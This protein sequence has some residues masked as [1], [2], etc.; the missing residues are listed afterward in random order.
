MAAKHASRGV[1][2]N[3]AVAGMA[4][5]VE[6]SEKH[7]TATRSSSHRVSATAAVAVEVSV[8]HVAACMEKDIRTEAFFKT[9][10]AALSLVLLFA[11][12]FFRIV[13]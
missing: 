8:T 5:H 4:N 3:A 9:L 7:E 10:P 12:M 2:A 13:H 6:V 11:L 1:A